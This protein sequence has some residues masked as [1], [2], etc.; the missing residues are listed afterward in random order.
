MLSSVSCH[1]ECWNWSFHMLNVVERSWTKIELSSI[2]QVAACWKGL[3]NRSP[4]SAS[5]DL[6]KEIQFGSCWC[7]WSWRI[8]FIWMELRDHIHVSLLSVMRSFPVWCFSCYYGCYQLKELLEGSDIHANELSVTWNIKI[9]EFYHQGIICP[10]G[11][12]FLRNSRVQIVHLFLFPLQRFRITTTTLAA[13][14]DNNL[15]SPA[16]SKFPANSRSTKAECVQCGH[17][18]SRNFVIQQVA[19]SCNNCWA[20]NVAR[21]WTVCHRLNTLFFFL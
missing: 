10:N 21:C 18:T 15:S 11:V 20:T 4:V 7:R 14:T 6:Q 5:R 13:H 3:T 9:S 12:L 8:I 1:V 17:S 16:I 2:Q 19:T